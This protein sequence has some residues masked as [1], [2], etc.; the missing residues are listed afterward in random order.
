MKVCKQALVMVTVVLS[1]IASCKTTIGFLG[2]ADLADAPSVAAA[3]PLR[4]APAVYEARPRSP[5]LHELTSSWCTVWPIRDQLELTATEDTVCVEATRYADYSPGVP[6]WA[7]VGDGGRSAP[8]ELR[9]TEAS[10]KIGVCRKPGA[11]RPVEVWVHRLAGC[12]K[13]VGLV[14]STSR[15]LAVRQATQAGD[16]DI[17][18]WELR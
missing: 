3:N 4:G 9:A 17:A 2:G 14:V 8:L 12:A 15:R 11:A 7:I 5:E 18:A 1:C 6:R 13:N 10:R 16:Y